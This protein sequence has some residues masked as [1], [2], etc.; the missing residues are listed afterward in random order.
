MDV[1]AVVIEQ[2]GDRTRCTPLL[3]GR[4]VADWYQPFN[5]HYSSLT[6]IA[7][8]CHC[9]SDSHR[10]TVDLISNF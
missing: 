3:Q 1:P 8:L 9:T 4:S 2:M 6:T 7:T 10:S 5:Q